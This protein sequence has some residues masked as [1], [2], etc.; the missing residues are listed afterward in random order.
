M[1]TELDLGRGDFGVSR[2]AVPL[3]PAGY[4]LPNQLIAEATAFIQDASSNAEMAADQPGG[5][6]FT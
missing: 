5:G 1:G 3:G 6:V 2:M 4:A